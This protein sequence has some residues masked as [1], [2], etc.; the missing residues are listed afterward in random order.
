MDS[1]ITKFVKGFNNSVDKDL[2]LKSN[3]IQLKSSGDI[4]AKAATHEA[5]MN[6][7]CL[8]VCDLKRLGLHA[9]SEAVSCCQ[10]KAVG[11][12]SAQPHNGSGRTVS[13]MT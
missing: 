1:L 12:S 7:E 5:S 9:V 6:M 13:V 10:N 3:Y 8:S 4:N 2:W 11:K